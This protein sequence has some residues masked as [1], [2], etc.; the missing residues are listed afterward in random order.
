[1][2]VL[3]LSNARWCKS[4]NWTAGKLLEIFSSWL[5]AFHINGK[6]SVEIYTMETF[7]WPDMSS[8]TMS[9]VFLRLQIL[10]VTGLILVVLAVTLLSIIGSIF[11]DFVPKDS[12]PSVPLVLDRY[13]TLKIVVLCLVPLP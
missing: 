5:A 11:L 4:P 13:L 3:S 2:R 7:G 1:M 9:H 12:V 8:I 6:F 10:I